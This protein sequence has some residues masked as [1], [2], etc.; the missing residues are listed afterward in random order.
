MKIYLAGTKDISKLAY[1]EFLKNVTYQ[2]LSE[3]N[4]EIFLSFDQAISLAHSIINTLVDITREENKSISEISEQINETLDTNFEAAESPAMEIQLGVEPEQLHEPIQASTPLT[5]KEIRAFHDKEKT[6]YLKKMLKLNDVE[7]ESAAEVADSEN[8]KLFQEII[9]PTPGLMLDDLMNVDEQF[10]YRDD[11]NQDY[12]LPNPL[13]TRLDD[14]L[15]EAREKI[16]SIAFPFPAIEEIPNNTYPLS[17]ITTEDI[18]IDDSL[19]DL[20]KPIYFPQP[21]TDDKRDFEIDK[22]ENEMI[23]CKSPSL[24]I[25]SVYKK[26]LRNIL[27]KIIEDLDLSLTETLMSASDIQ[28][29]KQKKLNLKQLIK[30]LNKAPKKD[31]EK[32]LESQDWLQ[33]LI[34]DQ[35]KVNNISFSF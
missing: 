3:E 18:Y 33:K 14:I 20:A 10:S 31:I 34:D 25:G 1:G 11:A 24:T 13:K 27:N 29:K 22:G 35:I 19:T 26:E 21:S 5:E 30:R 9:N 8:E 32:Q 4:D 28:D 23:L 7:L 2:A 15:Q 16:N 12:T 17:E 6:G